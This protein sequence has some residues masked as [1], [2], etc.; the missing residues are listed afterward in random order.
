M[1]RH[2][3]VIFEALLTVLIIV[4]L[5]LMGMMIAGL[6]LGI[7]HGTVYNIGNYDLII[8]LLILIDFIVFRIKTNKLN[9]NWQFILDNW[10]YILSIIPITFICFNIFHLF[11][12]MYI[13]GLIVIIRFYALYKV[14]RITGKEVRK[15]P[16]KTKLD[17][18]TVILLLVLIIGSFLFYLVEHGVNYEVPNFESAMWYSVIS[19]TTVGYGDIVPITGI[20]RIIG[21]I[22]IFTGMGYVSL[23][24]ATLAFSFID[25]FRKESRKAAD[26][27]EKRVIEYEGKI[28]ELVRTVDYLREKIDDQ[29]K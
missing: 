26:R 19:M 16:S 21:I 11:G 24:T 12:Y 14:L 17:Y 9:D 1:K 27:V 13:I 5:L 3:Q 22:M 8:A 6:T 29:K 7:M 18:A 20:G 23:V 10:A 2:Y 28:D 4:D 25:F 15:Y